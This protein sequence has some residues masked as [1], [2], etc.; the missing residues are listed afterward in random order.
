MRHSE[1]TPE[2][3]YREAARCYVEGHQGCPWCGGSHQVFKTQR[4]SRQEY[5]CCGCEFFASF[6][7]NTYS[8]FASP[9]EAPVVACR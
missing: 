7:Q 5:F 3:W 9:G 2:E 4:G 1:H 6:D 8:Y